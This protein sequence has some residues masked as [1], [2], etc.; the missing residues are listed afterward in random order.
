MDINQLDIELN[1]KAKEIFK[2]I[3]KKTDVEIVFGIPDEI[4]N[5][6]EITHIKQGEHNFILLR[7]YEISELININEKYFSFFTKKLK[8]RLKKLTMKE[9]TRL[10]RR[11]TWYL[12]FLVPFYGDKYFVREEEIYTHKLNYN[13]VIMDLTKLEY[14]RF[15]YYTRYVYKLQ[16]L[17]K[18]NKELNIQQEFSIV[19][20]D[21]KAALD[22]YKNMYENFKGLIEPMDNKNLGYPDV[23]DE[24][25]NEDEPNS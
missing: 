14:D 10:I 1:A 8:L 18:L 19:F 17:Y 4:E 6:N 7:K 23:D 25:E 2:T 3:L 22:L 12:F 24:D 9:R 21:D 16:Q 13:S 5:I 20:D 15:L 11:K